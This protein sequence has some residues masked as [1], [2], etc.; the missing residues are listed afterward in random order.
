MLAE[1]ADLRVLAGI[2]QSLEA[3]YRADNAEWEGSPFAWIRGRP[4]RQVGAIG[5]RLVRGWLAARGFE[6]TRSGDSEADCVVEG[7]RV[8]VKFSTLWDN[9]SYRFQQLRD[10]RYDLAVC[11]GLSPFDA[12]CWAIPK[13]DIMRLWRTEHL[14]PTQ[15]GG[16]RGSDTAWLRVEPSSVPDWLVPFGGCLYRAIERLSELTGYHPMPLSVDLDDD[17]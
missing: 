3:E 13:V 14:I 9:G 11:L 10:Q 5:E 4:S 8:E 1:D 16:G 15:H 12:H 2:S 7:Q 6:V 17:E